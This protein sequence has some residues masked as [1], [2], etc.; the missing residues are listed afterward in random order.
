MLEINGVQYDSRVPEIA[1]A[2]G[3]SDDHVRHLARK[4]K[5]PSIRRGRSYFFNF[6]QVQNALLPSLGNKDNDGFSLADLG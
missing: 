1:S 6:E 5:I 4:N 2:F 3:Y